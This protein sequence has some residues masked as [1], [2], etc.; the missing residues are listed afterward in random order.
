M[1]FVIRRIA[2]Y[3]VAAWVA[4]T[5]AFFLPRMVPGDPVGAALAQRTASGQ[6]D[7]SCVNAI[8]L[9]FGIGN[10]STLLA[11]YIQYWGNLFH[12]NLGISY[13]ES[14][15]PVSSLI[16]TYLPWTIGLLGVATVISF[17]LGTLIGIVLGWRR[18]SR[19]DWVVPGATFF[20]AIPYFFLAMVLVELFATILKWFPNQGP[21][22]ISQT[23]GWNLGYIGSIIDHGLLPA[24]TVV[25]A[26][27]AGFILGM[28]NQMLTTMDEDFVLVARAKG[29][30][31]RRVV[32]Y[33]ARNAILPSVSNFSLAISLVVAGQILV[34]VVFS[35]P[36]IGFLLFKAVVNHDYPLVQGVFVVIV[37]VVLAANLIAD[38]VYAFIDPRA[39]QEA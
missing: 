32:W 21:Y 11:Q 1:R 4:I 9:E 39:R 10:H 29:L 5:V 19:L 17:V 35:Y 7:A 37:L 13:F 31:N 28:R 38:V 27:I 22:D 6:C 16:G 20:Q 25:L 8:R 26:S 3:V 30:P 33:A 12:G 36:G 2:F 23:P 24:V 14:S 34:E 15:Q 18:G